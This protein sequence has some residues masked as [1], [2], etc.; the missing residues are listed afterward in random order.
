MHFERKKHDLHVDLGSIYVSSLKEL[1]NVADSYKNFTYLWG[2]LSR[3]ER[4]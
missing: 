4:F 3:A 2:A 1:L